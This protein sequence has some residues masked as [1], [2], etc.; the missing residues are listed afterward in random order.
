MIEK[1]NTNY[2]EENTQ[3]SK[4]REPF[5]EKIENTNIPPDD[6]VLLML[7]MLERKKVVL[8]G[9]GKKIE[10]NAKEKN[11]LKQEVLD[12]FLEYIKLIEE[13]DLYY[14]SNDSLGDYRIN[15]YNVLRFGLTVSKKIEY[16]KM[17]RI[18]TYSEIR[19]DETRGTLLGY[20]ETAVR[21]F[22]ENKSLKTPPYNED[23]MEE[24]GL[25]PFLNFRMSENWKEEIKW[26]RENMELIKSNSPKTYEE[27]VAYNKSLKD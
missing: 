22:T 6:K 12:S 10:G 16:L 17:M 15:L 25:L 7:L 27:V 3:E 5:F 26:A 18:A 11:E 19:D 24:E 4:E 2:E 1:L 14:D 21:A 13:L 23:E 8:I 20:P 9:N